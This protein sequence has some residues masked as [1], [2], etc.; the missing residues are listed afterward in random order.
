MRSSPIARAI[1]PIVSKIH[2]A[3]DAFFDFFSRPGA[4]V[5]DFRI[6]PCGPI[7]FADMTILSN[8]AH[9]VDFTWDSW[10]NET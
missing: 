4:A 7:I 6:E 2:C 9:N 8:V 10:A 1:A 3:L 5:P